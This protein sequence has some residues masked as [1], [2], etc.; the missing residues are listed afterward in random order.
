MTL[1]TPAKN[2][3]PMIASAL[4]AGKIPRLAPWLV[5]VLRP[6][7]ALL[8]QGL[9][10]LLFTQLNVQAP[11]TAV[12]HWWTVYGTFIDL[13][14]LGLL[15][16]LVR[17]EGLRLF[18]LL[19]FDKTKLKQ[20]IFIGLG[21][22]LVIFPLSVFGGGMLGN[23]LAYGSLNPAFPEGGF[24]RSLP[25]W[26]VLFSRVLW[27]PLWSFTEELVFQGYTL[28]RLQTLTGS[29]W[30]AVALV[31]FSWAIQHSF[32]PWINTQHALY[33]LITFLPLT[34]GLQFV[35]LRLRR[36]PPLIIG[37]WLMDLT[38]VLL[39]VQVG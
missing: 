31:G 37:H 35:Y 13:I 23:L 39:L 15:L 1:S 18:D 14:C 19:S 8:I 9:V 30:L 7:L 6:S 29:T 24:I 27:W 21:I 12:R 32:L 25:L 10:V 33:L 36:L 16:W 22:F 17:R 11:G 20:D 4:A 5:L 38:S 26:A 3:L 2:S 28:P 34:L